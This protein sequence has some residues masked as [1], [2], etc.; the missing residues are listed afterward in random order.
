MPNGTRVV[1]LRVRA[2]TERPARDPR[3]P[4]DALGETGPRLSSVPKS[5][6]MGPGTAVAKQDIIVGRLLDIF[7]KEIARA[8]QQIDTDPER[9]DQ[10]GAVAY[11]R[12]PSNAL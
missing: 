12:P 5:L 3:S 2:D 6:S 8:P 10:G 11:A 7:N 1:S 9:H 4:T